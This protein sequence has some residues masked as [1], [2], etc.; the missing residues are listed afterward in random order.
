[1]IP[2]ICKEGAGGWF[3]GTRFR[4]HHPLTPPRLRR[5]ALVTEGEESYGEG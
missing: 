4:A 2:L 3:T 1:M 5:G